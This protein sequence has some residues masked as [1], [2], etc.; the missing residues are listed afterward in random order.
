MKFFSAYPKTT[1]DLYGNKVRV[2]LT[3]IMRKVVLRKSVRESGN[4]YYYYTVKDGERPEH[5]AYDVYG[6]PMY[7]WII[8]EMNSLQSPYFDWPLATHEMDN[9]L[10]EKY[11]FQS[12][13]MTAN[14][15]VMDYSSGECNADFTTGTVV[16]QL[17]SGATADVTYFDNANSKIYLTSSS[18][19]FDDTNIVQQD[20]LGVYSGISGP[21]TTCAQANFT[22]NTDSSC[23]TRVYQEES[24]A[25]GK[26][27]AYDANLQKLTVNVES[28]VFSTSYPIR[29]VNGNPDKSAL[30]SQTGLNVDA[31]HHYVNESGEEVSRLSRPDAYTLTESYD[32]GTLDVRTNTFQGQKGPIS[33]R[34]YEE[35]QNELKRKIK[36]LKPIYMA[37]VQTEF[38]KKLADITI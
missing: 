24:G 16:T 14:V 34:E 1:F 28:G 37:D 17:E 2:V 6:D 38:E 23:M 35:T 33:N 25:N 8:M 22:I 36:L 4:I 20:N 11:P 10:S 9:Y 31:P 13:I 5:I 30:V 26:A 21:I 29:E 27:V 19:A 18:G 7:Y 32:Q 12:L 3:D 15:F